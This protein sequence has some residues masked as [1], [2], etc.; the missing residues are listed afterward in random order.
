MTDRDDRW[1]YFPPPDQVAGEPPVVEP[2]S[3]Q[4]VVVQV[5]RAAVA[6]MRTFLT[7]VAGTVLLGAPLALLWRAVANPPVI[8]R[9][10]S[11]PVPV[12][13][14]SNQV[15]AVDGAFI[16]VTLVAGAIAGAFAWLLLRDRGPA[17][18]FGLAG[19]GLLAAFVTV[20]VGKRLVID[21]YLHSVCSDCLVYDGTL[22]LYSTAA[23]IVLPVAMLTAFALMTFFLD[24]RAP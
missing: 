11:G 15:F 23:V 9:T 18:P 3:W 5:A 19:G 10:A 7:T 22:H 17:G 6:P 13:P 12:A 8:Q 20:A 14:E 1:S 2:R 21:D 24:K 4:Q 16:V